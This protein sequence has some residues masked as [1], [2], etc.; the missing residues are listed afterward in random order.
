MGVC[1]S[2]AAASDLPEICDPTAVK[3][4]TLSEGMLYASNLLFEWTGKQWNGG[5]CTRRFRP[6]GDRCL[7]GRLAYG[8]YCLDAIELTGRPVQS[9]E[10]V[11]I[12]GTVVDPARYVLVDNRYLAA[13]LVDGVRLSWPCC[14]DVTLPADA[15]GAFE[16]VYKH[17]SPPPYGG[18]RAAAIL[19]YELGLLWTP[20]CKQKCRL[21]ASVT[22]RSR[23][24][25]TETGIA[26]RDLFAEGW[27]GLR[28][29]DAWLGALRYGAK[30]ES[31]AVLVPRSRGEGRLPS[32]L[33]RRR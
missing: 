3:P 7:R 9:I 21:P 33:R 15:A 12:D 24:G 6:T 10:S 26:G 29:V 16:I 13:R 30:H 8:C 23:Q 5:G 18:K 31:A 11:T 17:G 20:D 28:E 14:Q 4:E 22:S 32:P 27:T 1:T 2:W 25:V 19:G